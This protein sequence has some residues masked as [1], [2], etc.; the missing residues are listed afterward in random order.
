MA[1]AAYNYTISDASGNIV[2]GSSVEVR[3]ES[4][5]V[6]VS[7]Y[8]DRAGAVSIA[9]PFTDATGTGLFHVGGG[10]YK[11]T[12]TLGGFTRTFRFVAIGLAAEID[13]VVT[14]LDAGTAITIN[15][16]DPSNPI[17]GQDIHV[18]MPTSAVTLSN[19]STSAQNLFSAAS[20]ALTVTA[21]T[22]YLFEAMLDIATGS[23]SHT[24]AFGFGGTA[25]FTS[26]KYLSTLFSGAANAIA[27]ASSHL[28]VAA[29]TATVLNA[30]STDVTAKVFLRGILRINAGGTII[31][32]ITFSAGP[33]GTCELKA[34]SFFRAMPIGLN[35]AEYIGDWT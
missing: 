19:S 10:A 34:N 7:L 35:T 1:Y 33:G 3:R 8:S 6:L 9:N 25:T 23:T 17:I 12:A 28:D 11:I 16:A 22:T 26:V 29:A 20:D 18:S 14:G 31:P 13:S 24:K 2:T 27:T 30:A 4:D 15:Q 5:N 32:Q 21:A